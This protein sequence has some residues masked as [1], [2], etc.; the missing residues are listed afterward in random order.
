MWL[1]DAAFGLVTLRLGMVTRWG[2]IALAIGSVLAFTG[3][4]RLGLSSP[5]NPTIFGPLSQIGLVL[6]AIGWI[7]MGLDVAT[8]RHAPAT[9]PR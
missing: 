5:E 1:T 9:L 2:A 3:M 8:R 6:N 7:L 4:D